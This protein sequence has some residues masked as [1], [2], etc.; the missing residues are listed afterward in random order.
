VVFEAALG[1]LAKIGFFEFLLP[2]LLFLAMVYGMLQKTKA[3]SQE[4]TVNALI[5]AV[6]AFLIINY[7]GIGLILSQVFFA[8]AIILA[9]LLMAVLMLAIIGIDV[10]KWVTDVKTVG[11]IWGIVGIVSAVLF[12]IFGIIRFN[13]EI[14]IETAVTLLIVVTMLLAVSSTLWGGKS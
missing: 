13:I 12:S 10:S 4:V 11:P 9:L 6:S 8:L 7:T 3:V 14:N 2:W 5:A 1:N